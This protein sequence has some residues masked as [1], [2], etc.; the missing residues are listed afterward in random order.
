MQRNVPLQ[1]KCFSAD[2]RKTTISIVAMW[3]QPNIWRWLYVIKHPPHGSGSFSSFCWLK[4]MEMS[5]RTHSLTLTSQDLAATSYPMKCETKYK[6]TID[7]EF[8]NLLISNKHLKSFMYFWVERKKTFR[9]KLSHGP[10]HFAQIT[11]VTSIKLSTISE[12]F[13]LWMQ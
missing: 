11:G 10:W 8:L 9:N 1:I 7:T 13:T 6:N 4:T 3:Y 5:G 2:K 12:R